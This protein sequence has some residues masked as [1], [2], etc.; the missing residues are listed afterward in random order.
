MSALDQFGY[1][2]QLSRA[3]STRDLVVFGMIFMVPIAPYSVFGFVW[4][5][6]KGMVPLAYLVGL[7]GMFFT[8]MS[9]AAMSRAFPLAGSVYTYAHRGLHAIAGFFSGWL[10]LLDYILVPALLYLFSAAALRPILPAVPNWVWLVG[11]ISFNAHV[12]LVGVRLT[13]RI[14]WYMLLME[15]AALALF[16]FFGLLALYHGQGAG[17]LTLKPVYDPHVFSLSTVAGATSIAVLSF[18]GFDG[19]STLAEESRDSRDAVGRAIVLA[20]LL[21]GGLFIMQTWIATDLARGMQFAAPETAFYEI[22][23][24]AGGHW[25]RL[26]TI[27]AV[28]LASAIANAMAAQAA[29]ARILFAMARDGKLPSVLA[30]IHPRYKTPYVSTLLVAVISLLVGLFFSARI[31]DLTLIVNFGALT[32]FVLLHLS[33]I[34]HYFIRERS[35]DWLRHVVFPIAG[36]LVICYV[37]LEM[38]RSAKLLGGCWIAIGAVYYLVL[39]FVLKKSVVLEV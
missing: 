39:T 31:D 8:A 21:V 22:S 3:L 36:L 13:A 34:N 37:L 29:V 9:Y 5:D 18:L 7:V 26:I 24:R 17:A 19:I 15:L 11:F 28:V 6:A 32:G 2:E 35:G 1:K 23:E 20:L 33:V 27:I 12:N 14:N 16:V 10:I 4:A 25:L 30:R 38:D